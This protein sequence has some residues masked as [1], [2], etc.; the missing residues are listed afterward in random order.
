MS[1]YG[2]RTLVIW[3]WTNSYY[4]VTYNVGSTANYYKNINY[5]NSKM[6]MEGE[7]NYIYISYKKSSTSE[8]G[9]YAGFIKNY[10][11]DAVLSVTGTPVNN[12]ID[13]Y[14]S[15]LIGYDGIYTSTRKGINGYLT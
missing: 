8:S 4:F 10:N 6:T 1:N 12:P 15:L 14:L 5:A 7:W 9:N 2:D 13:N 3:L 11:S